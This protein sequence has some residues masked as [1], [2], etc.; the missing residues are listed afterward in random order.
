MASLCYPMWGISERI[1]QIFWKEP[2]TQ[3]RPQTIEN[4]KQ[5]FPVAK[6]QEEVLGGGG[7]GGKRL[8]VHNLAVYRLVAPTAVLYTYYGQTGQSPKTRITEHKRAVSMFNH[9]FKT[10]CH[11]Q[12]DNQVSLSCWTKANFHELLV[13]EAW[14]SIKDS[15]SGNDH[16]CH[17]RSL[18]VSACT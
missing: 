17:P 13:L 15:Q 11:V 14:F 7:G 12:E 2:T 1:S 8:T 3:S 10:S 6:T 9:D 16:N 18:Q 5:F 4:C